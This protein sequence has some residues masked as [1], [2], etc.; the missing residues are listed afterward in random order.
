ML[1][2]FHGNEK[3][4]GMPQNIACQ[5]LRDVCWSLGTAFPAPFTAER[6]GAVMVR[7]RFYFLHWH[8]P[9]ESI[10]RLRA[11]Q[12]DA[13]GGSRL[14][15]RIYD[16]TDIIFNGFNAHRW[17][18][19]TVNSPTGSYYAV[20][21]WPGRNMLLE[22]GFRLVN[23]TFCPCVRSPVIYVERHNAAGA[24]CTDAL[25][26]GPAYSRVFKV[27]DIFSLP[28]FEEMGSSISEAPDPSVAVVVLRLPHYQV[29][30]DPLALSAMR[31]SSRC[32]VMKSRMQLFS[33]QIVTDGNAAE[34]IRGAGEL[35][36]LV[37]DRIRCK[38]ARAPFSL[39]HCHEWYSSIIA[40]EAACR[41]GV[42]LVLT[43]HSTERQRSGSPELSQNSLLVVEKE[44]EAIANA[45]YVVVPSED[46]FESVVRD[47]GTP[48]SKVVIIPD[49]L[50][51]KGEAARS[52]EDI[53]RGLG[54]NQHAP[55]VLFAGEV[56][57]AAGAD[58][59]LD[60]A[61]GLIA[62]RGAVN[63]V[64]V[65]EGPLK[66]DLENRARARGNG[67]LCRFFGHA[68]SDVF[69]M[70]LQA[71]S[72]VAQP[73]R[74][75]QDESVARL[76]LAGG[77]PVLTTHQAGISCVSHGHNGLVAYDNPG[78]IAWGL[79]EMFNRPLFMFPGRRGAAPGQQTFDSVA[80][81]Y[82]MLYYKVLH[83]VK[84]PAHG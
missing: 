12:G 25:F 47:Y 64:F 56:S 71:C 37:V 69:N 2:A 66:R 55:L 84:E 16:V 35:A 24:F 58:L 19:I 18:D 81:R 5:E 77:K 34:L 13:F 15:I 27:S 73:A 11:A 43:L 28:L 22:A 63:F 75:R 67:E 32:R 1:H 51:Q 9:Q 36:P 10:D 45:E 59:L 72:F 14:V 42:P 65:G 41:L 52:S 31:V 68:S 39:I 70:L 29:G 62:E 40:C 76:A 3:R 23:N 20:I 38:H 50:F 7:P 78:S 54:L 17:F 48:S 49:V 30:R 74:A 53:K 80:A 57:Y 79:K 4:G 33:P 26:V 82:F 46:A 8:I 6:I 61:G 83:E 21:D 44:K 60:A